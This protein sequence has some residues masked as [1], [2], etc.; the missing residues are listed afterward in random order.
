MALSHALALGALTVAPGSV[1]PRL[2]LMCALICS[3]ALPLSARATET[4]GTQWRVSAEALFLTSEGADDLQIARVIDRSATPLPVPGI[5]LDD[6]VPDDF[7]ASPRWRLE[8]RIDSTRS[9]E[10][11]YFGRQ[12]AEDARQLLLQ[13]P[14]F[15]QSPFLGGSI[16]FA[17]KGFDTRLGARYAS[18][19]DSAEIRLVHIPA[20]GSW[21][22]RWHV[23]ARHLRLQDVITLTG[24]ETFTSTTETTRTRTENRL[25]GVELGGRLM[26]RFAG[27]RAGIALRAA[28]GLYVNESRATLHNSAALFDGRAVLAGPSGADRDTTTAAVFEAAIAADIRVGARGAITVAYQALW[29]GGLARAEDQ[30]AATGT[31]IRDFP[32]RP[33]ANDFGAN[34]RTGASVL[35]HGP[36]IG[37]ELA[38]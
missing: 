35:W 7:A 28:G 11:G 18:D 9:I 32:Q 2:V 17:N 19:L 3:A 8:R 31:T 14:P 25:W 6:L 26:R 30:L 21:S 37:F 12:T 24:V 34:V 10:V 13:D 33:A 4:G 15:A 22:P 38:L 20:A 1:V 5:T 29:V 36:S 16:P 27:D 23:A